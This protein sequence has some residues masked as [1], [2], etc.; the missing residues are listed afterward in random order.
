M[1][2]KQLFRNSIE[3]KDA[4]QNFMVNPDEE[5]QKEE[6]QN[7]KVKQQKKDKDLQD[8]SEAHKNE[9]ENESFRILEELFPG[10]AMKYHE[11]YTNNQ[12][13]HACHSHHH[14]NVVS[15]D[16]SAETSH[17]H[18]QTHCSSWHGF[19]ATLDTLN[20]SFHSLEENHFFP[21]G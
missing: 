2:N 16:K 10:Y 9:N 3:Y 6:K 11:D 13:Q 21:I 12:N 17:Q 7:R 5:K 14:H 20:L 19:N 18:M 8:S 15:Q 4:E 1:V